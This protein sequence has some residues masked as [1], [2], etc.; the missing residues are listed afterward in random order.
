MEF[1]GALGAGVLVINAGVVMLNKD[2]FHD[3]KPVGFII[4]IYYFSLVGLHRACGILQKTHHGII[5]N[6]LCIKE[7][8]FPK[9]THIYIKYYIHISEEICIRA[10]YKYMRLS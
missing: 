4:A 10:E 5:F 3:L 7:G 2:S 6:Q 9:Y 8:L 1:K